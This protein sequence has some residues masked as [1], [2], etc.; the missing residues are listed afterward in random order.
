MKPKYDIICTKDVCINGYEWIN[1]F[2]IKAGQKCRMLDFKKVGRVSRED[3]LIA[4]EFEEY[5]DG[6]DAK[7]CFP[8]IWRSPELDGKYGH[9]IYVIKSEMES[10]K[11]I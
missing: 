1:P 4:L 10:F 9:C 2:N 3:M 6:H 7:F 5:I 11:F 8:E